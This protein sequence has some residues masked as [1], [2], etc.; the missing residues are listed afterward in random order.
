MPGSGT[1]TFLEPDHYEASLR[2]A[3]IETIVTPRGGFKARLT[4]AE[5]HQLQLLHCAEDF[6]RIAYLGLESRLVFVTFAAGSGPFPRCDGTE[7]QPEN[8]ILHR[9]G[10]R[11]HQTTSGPSNWSA[12]AIDPTRLDDYVQ[13]LSGKPL[14]APQGQVLRAPQRDVARLRRLHAQACRLAE[15]NAKMLAHPE[16]ARAVEQGLIEALV[17]CLSAAKAQEMRAAKRH[18]IAIMARFEEVLAEHPSR[19]LRISELCELIGVSRP[20]L[21]S[22]CADF[23]GVGPSRYLLL[24]RLKLVRIALRDAD[25]DTAS[26]AQLAR[27]YGF[28]QRG[29]F[30]GVYQAAFGEIPSATLQR[31]PGLPFIRLSNFT[32]NA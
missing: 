6:P 11:L 31:T 23:L 12:I 14:C 7:L 32:E 9:R 3:L 28:M 2:Q 17:T 20:T 5:L 29:R 15:T 8:I 24:R 26:V 19:P 25:P 13:V 18:H 4:W 1:R 27:R 10:Q 16:V 21:R 22:C 30:A